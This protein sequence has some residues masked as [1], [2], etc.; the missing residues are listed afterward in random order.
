MHLITG[1]AVCVCVSASLL[2]E[3]PLVWLSPCLLRLCMSGSSS[4][5]LFPRVHPLPASHPCWFSP[6][7]AERRRPPGTEA[8]GGEKNLSRT[9]I[10]SRNAENVGTIE[11]REPELS[12]P[13]R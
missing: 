12:K 13:P 10:W 5:S 9:F 2:W 4:P 7:G 8:A 6:E 1:Y 3:V 11:E